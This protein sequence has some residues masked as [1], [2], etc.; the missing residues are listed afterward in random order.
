[1]R[2]QI[3]SGKTEILETVIRVCAVL[4]GQTS[5]LEPWKPEIKMNELRMMLLT[6]A[7]ESSFR[8][9]LQHG[10]GPAKGLCQMEP[11]TAFDT[12]RWLKGKPVIW[13]RLTWI[14]MQLGTVPHFTPTDAEMGYFLT[15]HDPFALALARVHYK[16]FEE[17]FPDQLLNQARYWKKYWNTPLGAHEP[18]HAISQ[19]RACRCDSLVKKAKRL[20]WLQE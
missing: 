14:W 1:M 16:M 3:C 12:F 8:D 7:A 2:E 19:W 10:G 17:P 11:A 20:C 18:S 9:R 5:D 15:S 13:Q 4:D 6:I